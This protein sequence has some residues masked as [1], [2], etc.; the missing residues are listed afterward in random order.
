LFHIV[1]DFNGM[2]LDSSNT[3]CPEDADEATG[4]APALAATCSRA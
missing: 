1:F 4:D 2:E 3:Q